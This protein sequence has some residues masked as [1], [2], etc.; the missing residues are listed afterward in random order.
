MVTETK[1]KEEVL[2]EIDATVF[3]Y[4]NIMLTLGE[5]RINSIPFKDS[6][7]PGQLFNHVTKSTNGMAH[8]MAVPATP[9]HRD[10]GIRIAEL[11]ETFLDFSIKMESPESIVPDKGP[12]EIESTIADLAH[13]FQ[14]FKENV[15]AADLEELVEGLPLGPITKLELLYFVQYHT[16]RHLHQLEKIEAALNI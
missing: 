4:L 13:A 9:A 1:V 14:A 8:V 5:R 6:W 12:Y 16:Q 7:T 2:C 15:N 11:K 10:P 3:K